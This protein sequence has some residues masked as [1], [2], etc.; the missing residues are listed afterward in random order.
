VS[1]TPPIRY[2]YMY[3]HTEGHFE[4]AFYMYTMTTITRNVT[5]CNN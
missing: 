2:V 4:T 5:N 1:H 3:K